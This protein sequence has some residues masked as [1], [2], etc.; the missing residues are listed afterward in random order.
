MPTHQKFAKTAGCQHQTH[1]NKKIFELA[2][3][4]PST[5]NKVQLQVLKRSC[6]II[7]HVHLCVIKYSSG[8]VR[9]SKVL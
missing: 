8:V 6:L 7:M 2:F 5:F 3:C 1:C 9:K 4:L